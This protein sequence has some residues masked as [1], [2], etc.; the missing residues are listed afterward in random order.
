VRLSTTRVKRPYGC[1]QGHLVF[2]KVLQ[3][4]VKRIKEF[5]LT[6][7]LLTG[8]VH[9]IPR[10]TISQYYVNQVR[11]LDR[12][13]RPRTQAP[14][15]PI[16]RSNCRR[17]SPSVADP[18]FPGRLRW[19]PGPA[20]NTILTLYTVEQHSGTQCERR[21]MI[22]ATHNVEIKDLYRLADK[23]ARNRTSNG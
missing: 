17:V 5:C 10:C 8:T 2:R 4:R 1:D 16:R 6:G 14:I 22:P 3:R 11:C 12:S 13:Y 15:L 19:L 18:I 21:S 7:V 9:T 23:Q 20:Y